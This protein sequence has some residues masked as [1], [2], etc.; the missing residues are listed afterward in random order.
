MFQILSRTRLIGFGMSGL[1]G[2]L[3]VVLVFGIMAAVS[4]LGG[5][6]THI[7]DLDRHQL[8][9]HQ[10]QD[11]V[12]LLSSHSRLYE[13]S[14]ECDSDLNHREHDLVFDYD[15]FQHEDHHQ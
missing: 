4:S 5:G 2:T 11:S 14:Y 15:N 12:I 10:H 8:T 13:E 6:H 3:I 9:S 1:L 7:L